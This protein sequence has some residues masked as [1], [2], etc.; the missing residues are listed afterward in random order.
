MSSW[1]YYTYKI[2]HPH[3]YLTIPLPLISKSQK[4]L[5][6][7]LPTKFYFSSKIFIFTNIQKLKFPVVQ[8]KFLARIF[9]NSRIYTGNLKISREKYR[10]FQKIRYFFGEI[11]NRYQKLSKFPR[12]DKKFRKFPNFWYNKF[13][14]NK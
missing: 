2:C 5:Y 13:F 14:A 3:L 1:T 10:K 12:T 8:L 7:Y 11:L 9:G 4:H 6:Y